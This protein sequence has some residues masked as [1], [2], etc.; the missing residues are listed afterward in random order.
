VI[1]VFV[2]CRY[3]VFA[4]TFGMASS[5]TYYLTDAVT[6]AFVNERAE[7]FNPDSSFREIDG[8]DDWYKVST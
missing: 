7:A 1:T 8:I 5:M 3:N 6:E 4:V 2:M